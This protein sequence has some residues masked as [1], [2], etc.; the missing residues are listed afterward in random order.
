MGGSRHP[1][2]RLLQRADLA[3]PGHHLGPR[4]ARLRVSELAR[5]G[6][7]AARRIRAIR[8]LRLGSAEFLLDDV[9]RPGLLGGRVFF[10][11][12]QVI[13][14][15]NWDE[16][17]DE[18][19]I[20]VTALTDVDAPLH[21][22][23]AFGR[24]L[25]D[26]SGDALFVR[27]TIGVLGVDLHYLYLWNLGDPTQPQIGLFAFADYNHF[28]DITDA[29][30]LQVGVRFVVTDRT[31]GWDLRAGA[32]Y[33]LIGNRYL[34]EYFDTDYGIQSQRFGLT[35]DALAV[36]GVDIHTTQLEYMR[37]RP[38]G[39]TH[40]LQAY[41]RVQIPIPAN[42][43]TYNPLPIAAFVEE[44]DG[45]VNAAFSLMAGPFRMDQLIVMALDQRRNFDSLENIFELDGTLIRV[46][47]RLYLGSPDA[48]PGS[49]AQMM[50]Y[51][52]I[53]LRY[54]HRFFQTRQGD[55][56]ETHDFALTAGFRAGG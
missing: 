13:F 20:G 27:D 24:G 1:R 54:D 34:P 41:L 17:P 28:L 51:F 4:H 49:F 45:P 31:T 42:Q 44:A 7:A 53:D 37:L 33:R 29:N 8:S 32:E 10:R 12:Q 16:T 26:Q 46:L 11:P 47:G 50:Q 22:V 15:E 3:A 14:G 19:A 23:T 18:L 40:G 30:A 5:H 52:H 39:F 55:Y 56:A 25:L 48:E 35:N 43:G 9:T 38:G 2:P 36:P 21:R 6:A